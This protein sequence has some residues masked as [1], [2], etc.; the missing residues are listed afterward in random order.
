VTQG[1]PSGA[2]RDDLATG[3]GADP[4]RGNGVAA[5]AASDGAWSRGAALTNQLLSF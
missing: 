5:E 2:S 3:E 4:E 1:Q